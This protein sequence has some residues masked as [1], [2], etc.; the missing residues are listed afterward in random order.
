MGFFLRFL[1]S[2]LVVMGLSY[3]LP[4]IHVSNY[5]SAL[6]LVLILG[7]LNFTVKP[8]LQLITIPITILTLGL[9]LLVINVIVIYIAAAIAPGFSVD[10]FFPALFF[11]LILSIVNSLMSSSDKD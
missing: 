9:F 10:G 3:V 7:V 5:V 1:V 2:G 4:G 11:S 8:L 6:V